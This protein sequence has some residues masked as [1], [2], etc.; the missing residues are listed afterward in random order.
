MN[1]EVNLRERLAKGAC[2]R[3]GVS[4]WRWQNAG[5]EKHEASGKT[6]N[7]CYAELFLH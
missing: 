5:W 1:C 7:C 2:L 6:T 4:L 3:V